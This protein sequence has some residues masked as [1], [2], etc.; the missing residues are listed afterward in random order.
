MAVNIDLIIVNR[1]DGRMLDVIQC[2]DY[3]I[4]NDYA[5]ASSS[6]FNMPYDYTSYPVD[7]GDFIIA[8]PDETSPLGKNETVTEWNG[9]SYKM[10]IFI[11][12]VTALQ[13]K[14]I[15]CKEM[16]ELFDVPAIV[17]TNNDAHSFYNAMLND[18][19]KVQ[20]R[21]LNQIDFD[22][23][24]LSAA[25]WGWTAITEQANVNKSVLT[26]FETLFTSSNTSFACRGYR[27]DRGQFRFLMQAWY[28]TR[29]PNILAI[30]DESA[31]TRNMNVYVK[32]QGIG[33][34]NAIRI[35]SSEGFDDWFME[36]NGNIVHGQITEN[37]IQPTS[38][39]AYFYDTSQTGTPDHPVPTREQVARG[40]LSASAYKHEITFD[41]NTRHPEW[42][43][44]TVMGA[45]ITIL[46]KGKQYQSIVSKLEFKSSS[47]WI[48]VTCGALRSNLRAVVG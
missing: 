35:Y 26:I 7:V 32:D 18:W 44:S 37:V 28:G 25:P 15:T 48:T 47:E 16:V 30:D 4:V 39:L 45:P 1:K 34:N 11:G 29:G 33:D 17:N 41:V 21:C 14:R 31:Y 19:V 12:V 3:D 27:I 42:T 2:S 24:M 46:Y 43:S 23:E 6:T 8:R 38:P 36:Q 13:D 9:H 22:T 40:K 20:G 10:P 5:S